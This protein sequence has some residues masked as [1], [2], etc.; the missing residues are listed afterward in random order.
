MTRTKNQL[1]SAKWRSNLT[2]EQKEEQYNN[3]RRWQQENPEKFKASLHKYNMKPERKA[4]MKIYNQKY[5]AEHLDQMR[6]Q[7]RNH[8]RELK[9][10]KLGIK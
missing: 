3:I 2:D 5:R 1:S 9:K 10:Q 4:A 8:K 6:E 7:Q